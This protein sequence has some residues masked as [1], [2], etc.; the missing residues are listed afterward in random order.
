[1]TLVKLLRAG[2]LHAI[3]VP[4][5]VHEAVRDLTRAREVAMIAR[6]V[7]NDIRATFRRKI[8]FCRI[9]GTATHCRPLGRRLLRGRHRSR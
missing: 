4:D 8:G 9:Q 7:D 3:W 1:M 5:T 2:E 6:P